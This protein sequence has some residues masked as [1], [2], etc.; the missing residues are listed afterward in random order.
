[1]TGTTAIK[2]FLPFS[3]AFRTKPQAMD[4][5]VEVS[6]TNAD[7][8]QQCPNTKYQHGWRRIVRNFTPS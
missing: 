3:L 8:A 1:M 6:C 7:M 5:S 2:L 4:P